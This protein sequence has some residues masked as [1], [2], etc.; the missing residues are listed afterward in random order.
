MHFP[1]TLR[2][3]PLAAV[4][5]AGS[6]AA[7]AQHKTLPPADGGTARVA[8]PLAGTCGLGQAQTELDISSVSARLFNLGVLFY[9]HG[10][11]L[12]E[13]AGDGGHSPMFAANLWVSGYVGGQLR[14]AAGTYAQGMAQ[15]EFWPGPLNSDGTLPNPNDCSAYDRIWTV[16]VLDVQQ[17]EQTGVASADLADWPYHL[18]APVIDGDGDPTNYNLAGGD[19]PEIL[20]HQTA[21]W[22]MNDRGNLHHSTGSPSMGLEVQVTA[23]SVAS[24]APIFDTG[25]FYRYRLINRS[26]DT[27]EDAR[28]SFW[29]D[30]DIGDYFTDYVGT[31]AARN[32]AYSYN[33][34]ATDIVYG[35]RPPAMGVLLFDGLAASTYSH[36][37]SGDPRADPIT[38]L[39]QQWRNLQVGL[40]RDGEPITVGGTGRGGSVPT[41]L[42]FPAE[43][44]AFWS[45]LCATPGCTQANAP[46]DR[47]AISSGPSFQLAPGESRD[48]HL[49]ILYAR[50][51]DHLHSVAL[52][53]QGADLVRAAFNAGTLYAPGESLG[54]SVETTY[55]NPFNPQAVI[56]FELHR[57]QH[58]RLRVFDTLG[59]EVATL[60]DRTLEAGRHEA[61]FDASGLPS[62][63]YLYVIEAG[64]HRAAGRM[65]LLR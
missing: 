25:T 33:A 64:G 10:Q 44:G 20:G 41:P 62:G 43:P 4:L 16:S 29:Y 18:G 9:R 24:A 42:V 60:M 19:R 61:L 31:D 34:L 55:P 52:L 27:I 51:D 2:W 15:Y 17:Y 28:A 14:M 7:F 38:G 23:F 11:H 56:P 49:A 5:I 3:L 46:N 50:G 22:V 30:I 39:T 59:R 54:T 48:V 6:P 32:L 21:W 36:N 40:W 35:S 1:G 57:T 58:V 47:R 37:V 63:P 8:D 53:K 65:T 13:V 26:T 12:Y 45:E